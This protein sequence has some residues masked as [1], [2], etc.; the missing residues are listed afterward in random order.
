MSNIN[1]YSLGGSLI[2]PSGLDNGDII[3]TA[4]TNA[5]KEFAIRRFIDHGEKSVVV[6]GGGNPAR[7]Y[8]KNLA[9]IAD[10]T[11]VQ[12]DLIGIAATRVNA[13]FLREVFGDRAEE[14]IIIDPT[15]AP[16]NFD[17]PVF[18][19]A[20]WKPGWST[21]YV[22][23][24]LAEKYGS[25]RVLNLSNISHVYA[26]DPNVNPDAE[27]FDKLSWK[28][29]RATMNPEWDPGSHH[30]FDP[31]AS[32]EAHEKGLEVIVLGGKKLAN[33]TKYLD[34]DRG[35]EGTIIS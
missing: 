27:R 32:K 34:G 17:K 29:Y 2:A 10:A 15:K 11:S 3:D 31:I 25:D 16:K 6:I 26:E 13:Q 12:K 20:G 30:P 21:D 35:F 19:A 5:F 1:L 18:V 9:E 24:L 28:D 8:L 14:E 4:Y 22:A 33:V 7:K 23:V